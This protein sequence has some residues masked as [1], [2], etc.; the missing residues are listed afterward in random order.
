MYHKLPQE[1]YDIARNETHVVLLETAR[2]DKE[3][4]R[5]YLF[6]KPSDILRIDDINDVG[7][8]LDRIES[9]V[10]NGYYV[11][12][13]MAYECGYF[14]EDFDIPQNF[15]GPIATF[16]VFKSP[17]I[18]N[19]R[20]GDIAGSLP[21]ISA[22]EEGA[23][24]ISDPSFSY[25]QDTYVEKIGRIKSHIAA[26]DTYQIN[27]TGEYRFDFAGDPLSF[28]LALRQKQQVSYSAFL[29]HDKQV[30]LSLS[31]ELFF[32]VDGRE[33]M[34]RPMKGTARRGRH[35]AEDKAIAE[36]LRSDEKSQAENLMIVDLLRNDVGRISEIGSV[37]VSD[38]FKVEKYASL[39]QMITTVRARL[40]SDISYSDMFRALFPCGSVTGAPK[41]RS[42]EIIREL[43]A[44]ERGI[45]TGAIGFISPQRQAVFSVPIR[46]VALEDGKG[47]MGSGSGI[48]W[49]SDAVSEF[50]ECQLK[51]NFLTQPFHTIQLIETMLA[52]AGQFP[53][54]KYHLERL[55]RSAAYFM[56]P[57]QLAD[58]EG[59]LRKTLEN[60][61]NGQAYK[62]R[63]LLD[64]N[65]HFQIETALL[66]KMDSGKRAVAFFTETVHSEDPFLYHKT[67]RREL[68]NR[69]A[70]E[71]K[72]A[73]LADYLFLNER[74][75]VTEGAISNVFVQ[76]DGK[77]HTPPIDSGVLAG[78]FRSY[79]LAE[80]EDIVESVLYPADIETAEGIFICNA[81]RGW[82]EVSLV[83][84]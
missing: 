53:L 35:N 62:V 3:N 24:H 71:A 77:L 65:G 28:Y 57:L 19:H 12:G 29:K 11:A 27:F 82:Q 79:V 10:A 31:P 55:S 2:F 78:V 59:A 13:Y 32:R 74:G 51:A 44:R 20:S 58:I 60:L 54:L 37:E 16:G 63:L 7:L 70:K 72:E 23:Y 5:S 15:S 1:F 36:W 34:T 68:Y 56:I 42:M 66:P 14:F 41:I 81:V 46:T 6:H 67:T 48:V 17:L 22:S 64:R 49:D 26:G 4:Y 75:E 33:M 52:E 21:V 69:A 47:K 38:L 43:E 83:R 73:G 84:K 61:K 40:R 39:F 25:P 18:F 50:R 80:K 45:Y 30:Y 9:V 8:L 76:R